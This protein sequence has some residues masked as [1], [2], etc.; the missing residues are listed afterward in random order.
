MKVSRKT[1]SRSIEYFVKIG[2]A[3]VLILSFLIALMAVFAR[4]KQGEASIGY[5]GS[6]DY[7]KGWTMDYNGEISR[8]EL[9]FNMKVQSG[10]EIVISNNLP[11]NLADGMSL[12]MRSSMEDVY[13]Y[14]DGKLRETYASENIE[15]MSYYIPSAYIV[16]SL[17][18]DDSG[19]EIRILI[20][21]KSS[22]TVKEIA[23]GN[24]NN[25]W[26]PVVL[27]SLPV[28]ITALMV[29]VLGIGVF[30]LSLFIGAHTA[31]TAAKYLG[32]LM[33]SIGFW[34]LSESDIRQ[35]IFVKPSMSQYFSYFSMEVIGAFACM[36]FDEV[37]HR[38][39]HRYYLVMESIVF[40]QIMLNIFLSFNNI[41]PLYKTLALS[42]IWLL[43]CVLVSIFTIFTDL[44]QKR[45]KTYGITVL[46]MVGF[47]IA[48]FIEI[49]MFY[50]VRFYKFGTFICIGMLFLLAATLMQIIHDIRY[51][52]L[53]KEKKQTSTTIHTIE[54]IAGAID[55][56]DVYTGGH[57]ERVGFYA[58][59]LA[60]E[61]AADYDLSEED[62]L[63]VQ[64]IGLVHDIGK[65]GVADSVLN[66]S[67]RLTDEEFS[68][69]KKHA[70]IGYEIMSSLDD[71]IDGL[72]D[73]IRHHHE[74]FDGK[75]YPDGLSDTDIPLIARILAL[76]DSY[77]AMTSN[78]IYRNRLSDE[79]V[80][81]ELL[82]NSGTQFDPALTKIFVSLLDKGELKANTVEGVAADEGGK[83]MHSSLL[84]NKLQ[85]D[86][87]GGVDVLNPTH[88]RMLGYVIKLKERKGIACD[89]LFIDQS[90][91]SDGGYSSLLKDMTTVG[92][93]AIK[94]TE[95][96]YIYALFEK[97]NAGINELINVLGKKAPGLVVYQ[98][99]ES[100]TQY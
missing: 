42:H 25:V 4:N 17:N 100:L 51:E 36:Y 10:D 7:N 60:R 56:R 1:I 33:F 89:V 70:E 79:K 27:H 47:I 15:N 86:L 85:K 61:M 69:M 45:I 57:S 44:I 37:Q 74:R 24:G 29:L 78:R 63:R 62:I 87:L 91:V 95:D 82:K 18:S 65:I 58:S 97:S 77:D 19:K 32:L 88:V 67:G 40:A 81:E 31:G 34:V 13:I 11:D 2:L 94:Y 84:D 35:L 68:L 66:K 96:I 59:R 6:M 80:R 23:I 98:L 38:K 39:Y 52:A 53:Q 41:A 16:T 3:T 26:F 76:A 64:Y 54:T 90:A 12:M 21:C 71:I 55:A 22:G 30:I 93:I 92:D 48:A 83:V 49:S 46:G 73:G 14:V 43:I 50:I 5:F 75:G 8:I 72:L 99:K 28:N 20:R 9:P